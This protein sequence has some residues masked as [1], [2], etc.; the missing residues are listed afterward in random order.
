M[1]FPATVL[2][3]TPGRVKINKPFA[4]IAG[5]GIAG[6]GRVFRLDHVSVL[7]ELVYSRLDIG[8][9]QAASGGREAV[10]FVARGLG[11]QWFDD[12]SA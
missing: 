7:K 1:H 4:P 10:E 8:L 12:A 2:Q 9:V 3:L 6:V 5:F 11:Q